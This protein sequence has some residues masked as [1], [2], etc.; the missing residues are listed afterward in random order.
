M[1]NRMDNFIA[2]Q[3]AAGFGSVVLGGVV[4]L[5]WTVLGL[6]L[7]AIGWLLLWIAVFEESIVCRPRPSGPPRR[8][9]HPLSR[10]F[11]YN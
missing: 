10:N 4:V 7:F 9:H 2:T 1:N 5:W 6:A 8:I 11:R 3:W